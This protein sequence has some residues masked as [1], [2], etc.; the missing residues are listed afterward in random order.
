MGAS[1]RPLLIYDGDCSFCR[2][3]IDR[4]RGLTGD[5]VDYAPS[6]EVA[7]Q[8]PEIPRERFQRSVQ[9][10]DPDG[11]VYQGAEAVFRSLAHAPGQS[12]M[13]WI[14]QHLPGAAVLCESLY[15]LVAAHRSLAY[16]LTV[17]LW[18]KRLAPPSY[19]LTRWVF[20]R[21]LALAYLAAFWSLSGQILGLAGSRGILPAADYLRAIEQALGPARF[22]SY[23]TLGWLGASDFALRLFCLLGIVAAVV[24]V[25]G[26]LPALCFPAL[27]A[28]YLSLVV[29][30]Q[31]F[32]RFQWDILL[33][34]TGFLAIWF[35][36]QRRP[37]SRVMLWLLRALCFRLTFSSGAMKLSSGDPTWRNLTALQYHYET[38]PLPT[39]L[40]WFAHQLPVWFQSFSTVAMFT[41]ELGAP[42][43]IFAPRRLRLIGA[44]LLIFLQVLIALT[45]N[46]AFFNL[47]T[48][49][50]CLLLLDDAVLK[51]LLPPSLGRAKPGAP[52]R[53]R[54]WTAAAF[55]AVILATGGAQVAGVVWGFYAV[56]EPLARWYI[57]NSYGLFAVMTTAR[58]EIVVEGSRDGE[59]WIPYEFRYKPGGL[60]RAP[61]IVAPHQPRL[62]WQMWFAALGSHQTNPWFTNF[63][64]RLLEGSPEV[65]ALLANNPFPDSPPRYVRARRYDYRFT[66]RRG[67]WWRREE[68]GLY[69]P[70]ASLRGP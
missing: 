43:L 40:A 32:L 7:G 66:D 42:F 65:A 59:T 49:A 60:D 8:F 21:L 70:V 17:V 51:G 34:E 27:W 20:L 38:Q 10:V 46:Y 23:P 44:G 52:G 29:V 35:A 24:A 55:A 58:P 68:A 67:G 4:W 6:Q 19:D 14:Y 13:L 53:I 56:P 31:E 63:M 48:I 2:L 61:P 54:R 30:G 28:L 62:D 50:L 16:R 5:S 37:A 33:L 47:L 26:L 11:K 3:W 57:V 69:F 41:I 36:P 18:G 64:V 9:L 25:L 45:G 39:P 12:W 1:S 15:R 22:W